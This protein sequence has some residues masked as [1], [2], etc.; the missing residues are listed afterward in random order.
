MAGSFGEVRKSRIPG[1]DYYIQ[2]GVMNFIKTP[3]YDGNDQ[4]VEDTTYYT[5]HYG[6][7]EQAP[8]GRI[9]RSVI[10]DPISVPGLIFVSAFFR[11]MA[12]K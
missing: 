12:A 3:D 10:E 1:G 7:T 4:P 9:C 11:G 5:D 6:T 8:H 2:T